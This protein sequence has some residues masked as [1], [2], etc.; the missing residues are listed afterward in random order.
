MVE[1]EAINNRRNMAGEHRCK[2]MKCQRCGAKC[3]AYLALSNIAYEKFVL[4]K[5]C[6]LDG[7]NLVDKEL[8]EQSKTRID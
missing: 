1:F 4:C 8:L 5:G 6:L 7:S 3:S 2:D